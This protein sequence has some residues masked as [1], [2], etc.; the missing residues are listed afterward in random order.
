MPWVRTPRTVLRD[1]IAAEFDVLFEG[2]DPR[3]RRSVEAV[4]TKAL[5]LVS[6]ELHGHIDWAA[7]QIH[8]FSADA[9]ELPRIAA[10]WGITP[11]PA[12]SAQGTVTFAGTAGRI[13]PASAELRRADNVTYRLIADC[14]IGGDGSGSGDV[15]AL[16]AG[17]AGNAAAGTKLALIE[18]VAGVQPSVT[19]GASGLGGGLDVEGVE[20]LRARTIARIQQPPAGGARHD[21]EA[22][23]KGVVGETRVWVEPYA[24]GPGYVT[25]RFIMPDGAIPDPATVDLV[26][27]AIEVRRPVTSTGVQVLAPVPHLVDFEIALTPDTL[28]GRNAVLAALDD[29]LVREAE[30]GGTMPLSRIGAAISAAPGEQSHILAEPS[31]AIVSPPGEIAR[32]G[33]V[34][35]L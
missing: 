23:V 1:R 3:R 16:V 27:D 4:L 35:W 2:A 19:V 11:N 30:P 32:R 8:V 5:V 24:P 9:D 25:V 26:A 33:T 6:E 17:A 12:T 18:P 31:A 28:A 34:T 22:W 29:L 10:M 14:T 15:V 13:V 21:Y 7:R 20:S